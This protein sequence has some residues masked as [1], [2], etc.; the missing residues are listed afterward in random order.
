M[1]KFFN[2]TVGEDFRLSVEMNRKEIRQRSNTDP[3]YG[4]AGNTFRAFRGI[5]TPSRTYREWAKHTTQDALMLES[6]FES[7]GEFDKWHKHLAKSLRDHWAKKYGDSASF[8]HIF[9]MVDLY[10]KWLSCRAECP[11]ALAESI[12][13]YGYCALDSQIL[14]ALNSALSGALPCSKPSMGDIKNENT[15]EFCQSLIKEFAEA[16]G[17]TRLLFDFYAWS[18]G[19]AANG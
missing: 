6:G 7:Q 4:I 12:V 9:K 3:S 17:G 11:P 8:A 19:G 16:N 2:R 18:P 1:N 14:R 10:V 15:Y 13:H 5:K